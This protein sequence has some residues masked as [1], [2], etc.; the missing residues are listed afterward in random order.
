[1][2]RSDTLLTGNQYRHLYFGYTFQKN[3]NLTKPVTRR[4][5]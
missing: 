4:K 5:K 2:Q 1:M 3:I